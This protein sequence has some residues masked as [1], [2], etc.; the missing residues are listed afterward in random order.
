MTIERLKPKDIELGKDGSK[1]RHGYIPE[2]AAAVALKEHKH[3]GGAPDP[4]KDRPGFLRHA[5]ESRRQRYIE[6]TKRDAV[7]DTVKPLPEGHTVRMGD[8]S[9][10]QRLEMHYKHGSVI[11]S[12]VHEKDGTFTSYDKYGVTK[13]GNHPTAAAAHA[14]IAAE[15]IPAKQSEGGEITKPP[16]IKAEATTLSD[17][18]AELRRSRAA[19][20]RAIKKADLAGRDTRS[21][22]DV[23]AAREAHARALRNRR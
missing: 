16:Q 6:K 10:G 17:G 11:G 21:D 15:G 4:A 5:E 18:K 2:N 9:Q 8:N 20:T 1:W 13:T 23:R 22:P 12:V 19:L 14:A 7:K 3:S